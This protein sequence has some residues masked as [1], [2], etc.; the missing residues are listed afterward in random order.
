MIAEAVQRALEQG[1]NLRAQLLAAVNLAI[2]IN[3]DVNHISES[4]LVA[5]YL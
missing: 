5:Q 4:F 1:L 3:L 2:R